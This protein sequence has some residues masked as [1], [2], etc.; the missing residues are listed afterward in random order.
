MITYSTSPASLLESGNAFSAGYSAATPFP[1]VVIDDFFD[2]KFLDL[3][4]Q[5][6]L[7]VDESHS[8]AKFGASKMQNNKFAF[9]PESV[10]QETARLVAFLNSGPML[11]WLEK[12]TG[13]PDLLADPSYYGA[14]LH[15]IGNGGFLEVHA[16]FNHLKRYNLE[17]RINLLL[18]L[19]KEWKPEFKGSL[20]LWDQKAAVRSVE[21]IFNRCVVF[22]TTADSLH[23]HPDPLV[24]PIGTSRHSIALYYYTNTWNPEG[25]ALNTQ[26]FV[27]PNNQAKIRPSRIARDFVL[28]LI[29]PIFRKA[30][31]GIKRMA[32]G[33]TLKKL[34]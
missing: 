9:L 12:L 32:K 25:Q 7:L 22:S 4:A 8:Y 31:R 5:E 6:A 13:I 11:A 17:R 1:H 2:P 24:T 28:D 20:E 30:V 27:S 33:D 14:G 29:P 26:Y 16:D 18:Y 15:R 23:G 21:P 19:N 3:V 34:Q 10:G